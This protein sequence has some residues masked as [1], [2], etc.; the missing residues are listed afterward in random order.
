MIVAL[1][2]SEPAIS[3]P[4]L[5]DRVLSGDVRALARGI[6]SIENETQNGARLHQSVM[7]HTGRALVLGFTGPPGAGKST[8]V[9]AYVRFL[10]QKG[11]TVAVVAVDPS[12]RHT[13]GAL[14]GDR[15]RML[16]HLSDAGV[17]IRSVAS[18][19]HLGGLTRTV[20]LIV[21][22]IDAAGWNVILLETVGTGQSETEVADIAH[23]NIV[24][25][26]PGLGD[27]IQALKAGILET[28]DVLVINKSDLPGADLAAMQLAEATHLTIVQ[29]IALKGTGLPALHESIEAARLRRIGDSV[30]APNIRRERMRK[31]LAHEV[32]QLVREALIA[33]PSPEIDRVCDQILS[34]EISLQD[35]AT[36]A[37]SSSH[38]RSTSVP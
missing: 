25:G 13:G 22:L 14:L 6:S 27:D 1:M 12:S 37:L 38:F 29:T 16:D 21:D 11:L 30:N 33:S 3:P 28:A 36:Q 34:G 17:Y 35:A 4:E 24:V 23:V 31:R 18:R 19:G 7:V 2:D 10:R 26:A 15:I 8:L 5:A 32:S 9:D 20:P